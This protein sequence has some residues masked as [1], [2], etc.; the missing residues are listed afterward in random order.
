MQSVVV[1][2]DLKLTQDTSIVAINCHV[3]S[4]SLAVT[5]GGKVVVVIG[6]ERIFGIPNYGGS[7]EVCYI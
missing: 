1:P 2:P 3:H 7:Y 6:L 5:V 4:A